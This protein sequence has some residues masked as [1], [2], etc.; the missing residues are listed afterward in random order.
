MAYALLCDSMGKRIAE[1]PENIRI[2]VERILKQQTD[3]NFT[4]SENEIINGLSIDKS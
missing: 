3:W 4:V 1:E 2:C